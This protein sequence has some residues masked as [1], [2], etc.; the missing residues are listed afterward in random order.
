MSIHDRIVRCGLVALAVTLA[1]GQGLRADGPF[2]DLSFDEA[3]QAAAKENKLLF[4][5]FFTTWCGPCKLLDQ[6]TFADEGVQRWLREKTVALKV[7]AEKNIALA[8]KFNVDS[9]P[10]LVFLKSDATP[11]ERLT[12]YLPAAEFKAVA[13]D[14]DNG[15]T[16]LDKARKLVAENPNDPAA[17]LQLANA[18]V[19]RGET[20][21][22]LKEYWWCYDHGAE[23]DPAFAE[24]RDGEVVM[25]LAQ[26]AL[27]E[28]AA[29]AEFG[30]RRDAAE[31]RLLAGE[32]RSGDAALFAM[33]CQVNMEPERLM[34]TVDAVL[35]RDKSSAAA[36][37]LVEAALPMLLESKRHADIASVIDVE[38]QLS[39]TLASG[40]KMLA[41]E[42]AEGEMAA[43]IR[44]QTVAGAAQ[45]YQVLL[46]AG[47]TEAARA[48][49]QRILAFDDSPD[50]YHAL[51]WEG[52]LSGKP[53]PEN[54]DYAQRALAAAGADEKVNV[55]DTVARLMHALGRTKE[56]VGLCEKALAEANNDRDRWILSA[57]LEEFEGTGGA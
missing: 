31:K 54:V 10:T 47:R 5:D 32:A 7:D 26:L 35:A 2:R 38:A 53:V 18:L 23:K 6:T 3:K 14:L 22:A 56:A 52:Y 33:A 57:C 12:G 8:E 1:A 17:R 41:E 28:P 19:Q 40:K 42:G 37:Q 24:A 15:L 21:K 36:R 46:G 49:A 20:E 16:R 43:M 48:A 30:R 4:I 29:Q 11:F 25:M 51:A 39:D 27:S 55:I 9:Y 45:Y 34:T 13:G 50:S 44:A